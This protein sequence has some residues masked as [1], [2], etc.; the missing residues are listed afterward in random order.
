MKAQQSSEEFLLIGLLRAT[1][2][3]LSTRAN[4]RARSM[5]SALIVFSLFDDTTEATQLNLQCLASN[6]LNT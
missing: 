4:A 1:K 5:R 3:G 6:F 2:S